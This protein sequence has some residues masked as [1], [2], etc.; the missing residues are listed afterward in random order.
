MPAVLLFP[1]LA[2][3]RMD[4]AAL[5]FTRTG[6]SLTTCRV[7]SSGVSGNELAARAVWSSAEE[8]APPENANGVLPCSPRLARSDYLGN[9]APNGDQPRT[10]LWPE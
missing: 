8:T 2:R 4:H 5:V 10:G 3:E 6:R 1:R 9:V 7:T